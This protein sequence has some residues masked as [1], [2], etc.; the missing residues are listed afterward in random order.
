MISQCLEA[1]TETVSGAGHVA[2]S[3]KYPAVWCICNVKRGRQAGIHIAG[4][5][6][7]S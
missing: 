5:Q 7:Y 3:S 6:L 4:P 1:Q 2:L